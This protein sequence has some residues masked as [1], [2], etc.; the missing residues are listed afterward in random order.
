[1][2]L[3]FCSVGQKVNVKKINGTD[4]IRQHL[5][6]LGFNVGSE[7]SVLQS[8]KGN[9]IVNVKNCRLALDRSM[10]NRILV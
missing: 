7:I 2:P 1:M 6:E 3:S 10:A 4:A 5:N 8:L 9:L